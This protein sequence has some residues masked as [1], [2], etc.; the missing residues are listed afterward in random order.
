MNNGKLSGRFSLSLKFGWLAP[1]GKPAHG[2][3][4]V[5]NA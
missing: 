3:F 5:M 1:A 4:V 2:K